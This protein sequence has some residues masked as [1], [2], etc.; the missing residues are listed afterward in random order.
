MP[1]RLRDDQLCQR[2][3]NLL[4]TELGSVE[5]LRFLAMVRREPFDYQAWRDK[6]FADLSIEELVDRMRQ[7]EAGAP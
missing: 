4:E 3:L 2:A 1:E 6:E 5:T 7:M